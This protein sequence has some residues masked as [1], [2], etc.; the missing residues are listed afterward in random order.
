MNT[1]PTYARAPV[2]EHTRI[3]P[4]RRKEEQR[5]AKL[6][7]QIQEQ[8]RAQESNKQSKD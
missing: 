3:E 7:A 5:L 8:L 6:K 4:E 2:A 1:P